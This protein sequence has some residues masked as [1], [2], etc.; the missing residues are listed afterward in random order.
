MVTLKPEHIQILNALTPHLGKKSKASAD[1]ILGF[2]PLLSGQTSQGGLDSALNLI[3]E[4]GTKLNGDV[5]QTVGK[6][7]KGMNIRPQKGH[8]SDSGTSF[9]LFL[10]LILLLQD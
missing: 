5:L 6:L 4:A 10:L 3:A 7:M 9:V 2:L 8:S 1:R